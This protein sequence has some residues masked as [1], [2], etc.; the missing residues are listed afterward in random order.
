MNTTN[1]LRIT[2]VQDTISW[3]QKQANLL[4]YGDLIKQVA[5]QTD[6]VVLP[7][8]CTTGFSMNTTELAEFDEEETIHTFQS[9]SS[10]YQVA[11]AGSYMGKGSIHQVE[12]KT[13]PV[14]NR[15]FFLCPDGQR[16]FY[17]KRHLFRMGMEPAHFQAGQTKEIITYKGWH[18]Q[19]IICYDL[20]FPV[21]IRNV[22][23]AYDL[24]LVVA[25]WP[26]SRRHVWNTLLTAR[27]LENMAYVCGVNRI[28]IDGMHIAYSGDSK[29]IDAYGKTLSSIPSDNP[30]LQTVEIDLESLRHFRETFPVWKDAD[31]FFFGNKDLN[32][33]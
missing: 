21:W 18:I 14:Y 27:A 10:S 22:Q 33:L 13:Q 20:R 17:N 9:L 31:Y 1:K 4:H 15:G 16:H 3:E 7:E 19:L 28:G 26:T 8:L 2:L 11:I 23:N 25:N 6:L 29:L 5:G 32:D 30:Q 12:A 24:L